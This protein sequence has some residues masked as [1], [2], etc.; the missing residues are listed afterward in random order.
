M[1]SL[2]DYLIKVIGNERTAH[3]ASSDNDEIEVS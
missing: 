3:M 1:K 2:D